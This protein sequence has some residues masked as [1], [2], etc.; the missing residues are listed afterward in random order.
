MLDAVAL[1][2]M[3]KVQNPNSLVCKVTLNKLTETLHTNF[4]TAKTALAKAVELGLVEVRNIK[5]KKGKT[6]T[7]LFVFPFK[8]KGSRCAVLQ[9]TEHNGTKA[10][11]Y[12]ENDKKNRSAQ[13]STKTQTF[14]DIKDLILKIFIAEKADSFYRAKNRIHVGGMCSQKSKHAEKQIKAA[15]LREHNH[16]NRLYCKERP[17]DEDEVNLQNSGLSYQTISNWI[18]GGYASRFKIARLVKE[19]KKEGL[20]KTRKC[21]SIFINADPSD[22]RNED[23]PDRIKQ[24]LVGGWK[25]ECENGDVVDARTRTFMSKKGR[26]DILKPMANLIIPTHGIFVWKKH[27]N[28]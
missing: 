4:K 14:S 25:L 12:S 22:S 9:I 1:A 27:W 11:L 3:I 23:N 2:I 26:H 17:Y 18:T 15:D 10:Y 5:N 16:V 13:N 8:S 7:D 28:N 19:M 6:H 20:V 24:Y 21:A